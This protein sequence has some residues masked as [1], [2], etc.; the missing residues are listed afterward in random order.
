LNDEFK[1]RF[2]GDISIF[3]D[4]LAN[5]YRPEYNEFSIRKVN[6]DLEEMFSNNVFKKVFVDF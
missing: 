3:L 2:K 6:S 1:Q 5:N 4:S